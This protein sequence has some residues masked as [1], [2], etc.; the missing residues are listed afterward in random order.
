VA[1]SFAAERTLGRLATWLRLLGYDV[2]RE[3][4]L[5]GGRFAGPIEPG[6]VLLTRTRSAA[7]QE[8]AVFVAPNAPLDQLREL[9]R[10][11][12]VTASGIRPFTRC[13]RCN[14][15]TEEAAREEVRGL[16]P[17][18]VW[19]SREAFSRCPGCRRI[20]WRGSHTRRSLER[21]RALCREVE[22]AQQ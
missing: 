11:K 3:N 20:Y 7:G 12:I 15:P 13:L 9:V 5:P 17:D 14:L 4:D 1:L 6:R 22:E 2:V 21:F 19:E 16:V 10:M 18:Y 8:G